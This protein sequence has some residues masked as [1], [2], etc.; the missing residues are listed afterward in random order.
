ML[1]EE[2]EKVAN[3]IEERALELAKTLKGYDIEDE[4]GPFEL[5]LSEVA[6][7]M[8]DLAAAGVPVEHLAEIALAATLG[9]IY[10]FARVAT[11]ASNYAIVEA[12]RRVGYELIEDGCELRIAEMLSKADLEDAK[13]VAYANDLAVVAFITPSDTLL[14]KRK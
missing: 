14:F 3:A 5:I 10:Y 11:E 4:R 13:G 8:A 9:R 12:M 6:W 7:K 2:R 1:R